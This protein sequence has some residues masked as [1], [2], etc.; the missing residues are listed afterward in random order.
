MVKS[1]KKLFAEAR[2]GLHTLQEEKA[3]D[4]ALSDN[5]ES[6]NLRLRAQSLLD[7]GRREEALPLFH[8][9]LALHPEADDSAAAAAA[10]HDLAHA[11]AAEQENFFALTTARQLYSRALQSPA[12]QRAPL[13]SAETESSLAVCL[14]RMAQ[15][16]AREERAPLFEEIERRYRGAIWRLEGCG[17]MGLQQLSEVH[18]NLANFLGTE[19]GE[20]ERALREYD[21]AA[22]CAQRAQEF[23]GPSRNAIPLRARLSS[24]SLLRVRG[25]KQDF[26]RAEHL[27]KEVIQAGDPKYQALARMELAE[28]I[29]AGDT[30]DRV[31]CARTLLEQVRW[32]VLDQFEHLGHLAALLRRS[33]GRQAAI[34]LLSGFIEKAI[35]HRAEATI[36]DF[37]ADAASIDMQHAAEFVACILAQD[38]HDSLHAFLALENTSGFRFAEN[39]SSHVRRPEEPL[40]KALYDELMNHMGQTYMLDSFAQSMKRQAPDEQRKFLDGIIPQLKQPAEDKDS[41]FMRPSCIAARKT[42]VPSEYFDTL[43]E[44]GRQ[45]VIR[46]RYAL[47]RVDKTYAEVQRVLNQNLGPEELTTVLRQH[48]GSVLIRI[49]VQGQ[50]LLA[51]TVCLEGDELKARSTTCPIRPE[52]F[53]L[54]RQAAEHSATFTKSELLSQMLRELDLSAALPS[55]TWAR[56]VLLPSHVSTFL[57]LAALGPVGSRLIDRFESIIWLPSLFPLRTRPAPTSPRREEWVVIPGGTHFHPIAF[58]ALRPGERCLVGEEATL[59]AIQGALSEARTLSIYTHGEHTAGEWPQLE[60]K[61]ETLDFGKLKAGLLYGMERVEIWACQSGANLPH[62]PLTRPANEGYGLDHILLTSGV[63]TAIGTQWSVPDLV[64]AILAREYRRRLAAG[65]EPARALAGAQRQWLEQSLPLL[66]E[67][68][69]RLPVG[70]AIASFA[71]TLGLPPE[72]DVR[73]PVLRMLGPVPEQM[74]EHQVG[75]LEVRLSCPVAWAGIRFVGLPEWRA[76]KEWTPVSDRAL[77]DEERAQLEQ[78]LAQEPPSPVSF[79]E[80]QDTWLESEATPEPGESPSPERALAVARVLRDRLNS[81]QSDNLLAALAWVHEALAVPGISSHE[82]ERL[83]VEAAHLWLEVAQRGD[84]RPMLPYTVPLARAEGL[85]AGLSPSFADLSA[86]TMAARAR[87]NFLKRAHQQEEEPDHAVQAALEEIFPALERIGPDTFEAL[88]VATIAAELIAMGSPTVRAQNASSIDAIRKLAPQTWPHRETAA[89]VYR[90]H[91]LLERLGD[92]PLNID[93]AVGFLPPKELVAVVNHKAVQE[94]PRPGAGMLP[95][96]SNHALNR[97]EVALWGYPSDDRSALVRMT[98]TLGP[99]YRWMLNGYLAGHARAHPEDVVHLLACL[100]YSCDL[101]L[102]VLHRLARLPEALGLESLPPA[103]QYLWDLLRIRRLLHTALSDAALFPS[104]DP[105]LPKPHPHHLDPYALSSQSLVQGLKV[106]TDL[107]AWTLGETCLSLRKEGTRPPHTTAFEATCLSAW[108]EASIAKTW[109]T[110]LEADERGRKLMGVQEF[111]GVTSVI[112]PRRDLEENE[113]A[114][115]NLSDG[116]G[117]LGLVI[118]PRGELLIMAY[119]NDGHSHGQRT[120]LLEKALIQGA[121]LGVL[122]PSEEDATSRRGSSSD[123]RRNAWHMVEEQ[124]APVLESLLRIAQARKKLKWSVLAPGALRELPL[125]GLKL[126]GGILAHQVEALVHMP[127]IGFSLPPREREDEDF[128]ACLLARDREKETTGFGEAAVETLRRVHPPYL[129]VDP[130]DLSGSRVV[131]VGTLEPQASRIRTL[132]LYG[133][134]KVDSL[135]D[136]LALMQLEGQRALRDRNTHGMIMPRC[137]VV[138]IWACTAGS[139]GMLHPLRNDGDRIPGLAA[140]FL[141]NGALAVID[142]A[143]PVHDI[144]KALVCEHYGLIRRRI[145]HRPEALKEALRLTG[146]ALQELRRQAGQRTVRQVLELLDHLRQSAATLVFN[147]DPSQLVPFANGAESPLVVNLSGDELVEELCQPVHLAAFRWWGA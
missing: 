139:A 92:A 31:T 126:A 134:G 107:T 113:K 10:R 11:L 84:V 85:L 34:E 146:A 100:Q 15:Q 76:E 87:L 114:L 38:Q 39:L 32:N 9:A 37:E 59:E 16:V 131:E 120:F 140:S 13:R 12:R 22:D 70:E 74:S 64:T 2:K 80:L 136:T 96:A 29:L 8:Q 7:L 28:L 72:H 127:S 129:V 97:M 58:Q 104:L 141:A 46:L 67:S 42:P 65:D 66:L 115:R 147:I 23:F 17:Q 24:A 41:A 132:R 79:D 19:R 40:A 73:G 122:R 142:L 3:Y 27:A 44:K 135:N 101:R 93:E 6:W 30:P 36:S 54:I 33:D 109:A 106:D 60:L 95:K 26:K 63:R 50:E 52:V 1:K 61:R 86:D 105:T 5:P 56:A 119:W 116:Y 14:R 102:T 77:T 45:Q 99:A 128:T 55:E 111:P 103:M 21:R 69:R 62:D 123:M 68:L 71:G 4:Q 118:E 18:L 108:I 89:A 98:G 137:E 143:W 51:I 145:G 57:P 144:V 82:R 43:V 88:R 91:G 20:V 130:G 25:R 47:A 112:E 121:L 49:F 48:P 78:L 90:L 110:L 53:S 35:Q 138:E 75:E 117:V 81:S 83:S 94:G 124:L 125:L 133:V